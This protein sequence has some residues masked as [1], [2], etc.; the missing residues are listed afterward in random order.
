M[1]VLTINGNLIVDEAASLQ[2]SITDNDTGVSAGPDNEVAWSALLSTM[3]Q[4]LKNELTTLG[5]LPST[6]EALGDTSVVFPQAAVRSIGGSNTDF[7]QLNTTTITDLQFSDSSGSAIAD[8]TTTQIFATHSGA[9]IFLYADSN[10]NILLGREGAFNAGTG[11]WEANSAGTVAFAIVLDETLTSGKVSGGNVWTIQYEALKHTNTSGIDDA[12]TLDLSGLVDVKASFTTTT[13]VNFGDFSH[14]PSGSDDWSAIEQTVAAGTDANDPDMVI[15]GLVPASKVTVSTQG[16]GN[17]SQALNSGEAVRVDV[18]NHVNYPDFPLTNPDVHDQSKLSYST[19]VGS[20]TQASF[21]LTQVNPGSATTTVSVHIW[22]FN[23]TNDLQGANLVSTTSIGSGGLT[24]N[25]ETLVPILGSTIKVFSDL[26]KTTQVTTGIT[27]TAQGDG[28][29]I[30]SGLKTNYTVEFQVSESDH[31]DRFVVG[32]A[33]PAKGSGS[34]VTFDVGNFTFNV[35]NTTSGTEHTAVGGDL[36]FED[37]GPSIQANGTASAL[38]VDESYLAAGSTPNSTNTHTSG[39]FSGLF[40]P[41]FGAD[42]AGSVGGYTLGVK[43]ANIDSGLI[44]SLSAQS[45]LLSVASSNDAGGNFVTGDVIGKTTGGDLVF[46][47]HVDSTGHVTFTEFRAVHETTADTQ[48]TQGT[49]ADSSE[50]SATMSA[51]LITLS[52][53]ATDKDGDTSTAASANIGNLFQFLDDGPSLSGV[54][55]LAG[56][57]LAHPAVGFTVGSS[58]SDTFSSPDGADGAKVTIDAAAAIT[59]LTQVYNTDHTTITYKDSGGADVYSLTVTDTNYTFQVL[60]TL[61]N[62]PETLDFSAI[63]S[64]SPVETL[65]VSTSGGHHIVFD[66]LLFPA[67]DT[68]ALGIQT[69]AQLLTADLDPNNNVDANPADDLNPD[70]LGFG[71]KNGQAS[72]INMNEGFF[73]SEGSGLN[74]KNLA[75][76]VVGIGNIN[77]IKAEAWLFNAAGDLID[78]QNPTITGLKQAN[79]HLT[80]ADTGANI[81]G[82][83][84][85]AAGESFS[86]GYIRFYFDPADTNAG[87]RIINFTTQVAAPV[88]D[89]DIQ[90]RIAN[91][92]NDGDKALATFNVLVDNPDSTVVD[93][94]LLT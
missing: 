80:L 94:H 25:D 46:D 86:T 31:M 6:G 23:E 75:F 14:V 4:A 16:L 63:K 74:L 43:S 22:A 81:P 44:D 8:G 69:Q 90:F 7:I 70:N 50:A 78:Y 29:Y 11:Q 91:I 40:T 88:N 76:D 66:G 20:V 18:V 87:V 3:S 72:Q 1:A 64:G 28:S 12:D 13:T 67:A 59:G 93:H 49:V 68:G 79:A 38:Q 61:A 65:N 30:I 32:N 10:N 5:I 21:S 52:A 55:S 39:D 60:K 35:S 92:D 56:Q 34:N 51:D 9:Q 37:D 54:D 73:F 62:P 26:A 15:T 19:H 84:H 17:N 41:N 45:I 83:A 2:T 77:S 58:G 48:S 27:I 85:D 89:Q 36:L 57:D 53:T 47:V 24:G 42:G 82:T 71:V 33:Q